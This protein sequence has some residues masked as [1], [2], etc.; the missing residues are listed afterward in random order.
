[1]STTPVGY[2]Y[3]PQQLMGSVRYGSGVLL[4]NWRED[5]AVDEMRLMDYVLKRETGELTLL[6]QRAKF[7]PQLAPAEL[8]KR[9]SDGTM[10]NGD[11]VMFKSCCNGGA[12][13]ASVGQAFDAHGDHE[14]P[15][16]YAV[17][18]ADSSKAV[19]RNAIKIVCFDDSVPEGA[20][21][22]YGQ[23]VILC[24]SEAL[25]I[26]GLLAS[27]P[28]SRYGLSTQV[29]NKQ[30][31]YMHA[32]RENEKISF[33]CVWALQPLAG[34]HGAFPGTPIVADQ[35]FSL[36]HCSTNRRLAGVQLPLPSEFGMEFAVCCHTLTEKG[37]IDKLI[38]ERNG[39]NLPPRAE[40]SE[41]SWIAVYG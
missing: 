21:L 41:N 35:P 15:H 32:V 33:D 37:R 1:M 24:F 23:K 18:A 25:P 29:I 10:C 16:E 2:L 14:A 39:K 30:D 19:A 5:T 40:T 27:S 13:A 4:G 31:V 22:C 28:A 20:P 3:T 17:F 8:S 12:L 34:T 9:A 38:R 11:V 6:K 36:L 26:Q 7:G